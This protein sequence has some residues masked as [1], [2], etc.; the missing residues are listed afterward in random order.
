M[1]QSGG[2]AL[3][4]RVAQKALYSMVGSLGKTALEYGSVEPSG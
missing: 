1:L 2:F 3:R 4:L